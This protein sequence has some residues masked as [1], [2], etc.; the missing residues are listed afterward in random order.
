MWKNE[1]STG[2]AD[3]ISLFRNISSNES[4]L[5]TQQALS[6]V[7]TL[8]QKL[9][10]SLLN[11]PI[12]NNSSANSSVSVRTISFTSE[13]VKSSLSLVS[14]L[15]KTNSTGTTDVKVEIPSSTSQLTLTL[16]NSVGVFVSVVELSSNLFTNKNIVDTRRNGSLTSP[17]S[18]PIVTSDVIAIS[19]MSTDS[20]A[21]STKSI[22]P[23]FEAS[24]KLSDEV[25]HI[26]SGKLQHNCSLGK[27]DHASMFCKASNVWVNMSCTGKGSARIVRACPEF[28]QVCTVLNVADNSIG[29][30]DYC[31]TTSVST[32]S[33]VCRC[34][35]GSSMNANI[36]QSLTALGGK[37]SV[38]AVGSFT[39]SNLEVAVLPTVNHIDSSIATQSVLVFVSFGCIWF[40][41]L[42]C[43]FLSHY[44]FVKRNDAQKSTVSV[45]R[46]CRSMAREY[47]YASLPPSMQ[48]DRWWVFRYWEILMSK[49]KM[50]SV[51]TTAAGYRPNLIVN[52]SLDRLLRTKIFDVLQMI[53]TVTMVLFLL[54]LF[55][56]L[57]S[58]VDDGYC[59][60]MTD[61]P[62]CMAKRTFLD[63]NVHKCVWNKPVT[64]DD[65]AIVAM[66]TLSSSVTG[67][68]LARNMVAKDESDES[69]YC[70]LNSNTVSSRA[71]VVVF[72]FTSLFSMFVNSGLDILFER[73]L[74]HPPPKLML[75][76]VETEKVI[77]SAK[78]TVR[79]RSSFHAIVPCEEEEV[80]VRHN[81]ESS[82]MSRRILV[83]ENVAAARSV[84][85]NSMDVCESGSN[86]MHDMRTASDVG[87]D[88]KQSV[89]AGVALVQFLV[90]D[91]LRQS[92]SSSELQKL[93]ER[94]VKQWFKESHT[95]SSVYWHYAMYCVLISM[96][97]GVLS[98]MMM[99]AANRGYDWQVSFF[100]GSLWEL[101]L[102]TCLTIP[103]ELFILDY[104]VPVT[105]LSP[106]VTCM[107][108]QAN[109]PNHAVKVD[110]D[111]GVTPY[112][113]RSGLFP[114]ELD[115]LLK[116]HPRLPEQ[117]LACHV[118]KQNIMQ[119]VAFPMW[120]RVLLQCI[121][122]MPEPVLRAM[123]QLI[124]TA[125]SSLVVFLKLYVFHPLLVSHI[126]S[127]Y[128]LTCVAWLLAFSPVI[129]VVCNV[130]Y[131]GVYRHWDRN[132]I[133]HEVEIVPE[134]PRIDILNGSDS[135]SEVSLS[136]NFTPSVSHV[137]R[138]LS[139]A[140]N[141]S[142][143]ELHDDQCS[144]TE[145]DSI[146]RT[147]ERCY[148]E[149]PD[150]EDWSLSSNDLN[151]AK[152]HASIH[153][154]SIECDVAA[155]H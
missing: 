129:A 131:D 77:R 36:T 96:H 19:I 136:F 140:S 109:A 42:C 34:G 41:A 106:S 33:I 87:T 111:H 12:S 57:Q 88:L 100:Q 137:S 71:F 63:P 55:Y 117:F 54:A 68:V 5:A 152:S 155:M 145:L 17:L 27:Q 127:Y 26:D 43:I 94:E 124:A 154:D 7:D 70:E 9:S 44:W 15:S 1:F 64:H 98:F 89:G 50:M 121:A 72:L 104:W 35:Y 115:Q 65:D 49:H 108:E 92:G 18:A 22:L 45:D 143:D 142:D 97:I 58:P 31:Q 3:K 139:D 60:T 76:S 113:P 51:L 116:R 130:M 25:G 81:S 101:M 114:R 128:L 79:R 138:S 56:D 46:K 21:S 95:V 66:V 132:R 148:D 146:L 133:C 69:Q 110:S 86:L 32:G 73:L 153:I 37:I 16:S 38:A 62:S 144:S 93:F 74:A 102:D 8:F 67:V 2:I 91:M 120:K 4:S 24:L 23:V 99:K 29:S 59:G 40:I 82:F 125:S 107:I 147:L 83:S 135:C 149:A 13:F 30:S 112:V 78:M 14:V 105:L 10:Q 85:M 52:E 11:M 61:E 39:P 84:W 150:E 134:V 126:Q 90:Y 119:H 122:V 141:F 75:S 20:N 80:D 151:S 53:T 48:R 123:V 6:L 118:Y 47:M 103:I 28:K